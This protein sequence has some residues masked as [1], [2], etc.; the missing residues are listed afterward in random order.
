MRGIT[1][2][3]VNSPSKSM[4]SDDD[5]FCLETEQLIE[6]TVELPVILD[7][8]VMSIQKVILRYPWRIM[9]L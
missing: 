4:R 1:W 6:Q 8:N 5:Y 7:A 3:P 2:R 9:H